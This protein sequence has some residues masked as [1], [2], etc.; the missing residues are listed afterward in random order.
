[1]IASWRTTL[2]MCQDFF[3]KI[4]EH[5]GCRAEGCSNEEEPG[6]TTGCQVDWQQIESGIL[7][8]CGSHVQKPSWKG[9]IQ[10]P[11]LEEKSQ[12]RVSS[13][14][15][16][17]G[18]TD[19]ALGCSVEF[20]TIMLWY[21]VADRTAVFGQGTKVGGGCQVVGKAFL[22]AMWIIHCWARVCVVVL[23]EEDGRLDGGHGFGFHVADVHAYTDAGKA[24]RRHTDTATHPPTHT[25]T[26]TH[27][28]ARAR[29]IP[30]GFVAI[31]F[32]AG[33]ELPIVCC[34]SSYFISSLR[35]SDK[36]VVAPGD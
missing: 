30:S 36:D 26:H 9:T 31:A 1:M 27:T 20:G 11:Y 10:N 15:A 23:G 24:G 29:T 35:E 22:G 18:L 25:H 2:K 14:G 33:I 7:H 8:C 19:M 5:F 3:R 16:E 21:F 32:S 12:H 6:S 34:R 13:Q 28:R 4:K 17:K